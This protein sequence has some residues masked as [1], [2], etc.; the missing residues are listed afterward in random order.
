MKLR[1]AAV[2]V[3]SCFAMAA[4]AFAFTPITATLASPATAA[5]QP[6]AGGVTW[7]CSASACVANEAERVNMAVSTC[8]QLA[9]HVGRIAAFSAGSRSLTA[10]ELTQCNSVVH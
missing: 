9:R 1:L 10:D 6:I 5:T 8:K 4:P 2:C 3:A 7:S